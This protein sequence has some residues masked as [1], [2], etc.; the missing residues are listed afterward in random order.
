M[1]DNLNKRGKPDRERINVHEQ[2][3]FDRW[4][5]ALNVS[6]QQLSAAV[7]QVGPMVKNVKDYLKKKK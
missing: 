4:K 5:K 3:E 1:A 7:R 6:G 2:W